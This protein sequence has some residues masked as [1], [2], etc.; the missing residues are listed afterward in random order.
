MN[1][2]V[3]YLVEVTLF[4][5]C[6]GVGSLLSEASGPALVGFVLTQL[7]VPALLWVALRYLF[8][9]SVSVSCDKPT[10][11]GRGRLESQTELADNPVIRAVM[12]KGHRCTK[13]QHLIHTALFTPVAKDNA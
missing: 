3:C 2:I 7:V 10:C 11:G 1:K 6:L 5:L 12:I 9:K 13:C 8:F 4:L